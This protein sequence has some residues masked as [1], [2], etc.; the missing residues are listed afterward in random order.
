MSWWFDSTQYLTVWYPE[1][2]LDKRL[3]RH[4][5]GPALNGSGTANDVGPGIKFSTV[6]MTAGKA[7]IKEGFFLF[8]IFPVVMPS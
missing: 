1:H 3:L 5:I 4:P 7:E 8:S 2:N 6:M